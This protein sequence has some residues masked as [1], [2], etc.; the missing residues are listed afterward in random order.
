M[1]AEFIYQTCNK[2]QHL[3]PK[4]HFIVI[5]IIFFSVVLGFELRAWSLLGLLG[6]HSY[7]WATPLEFLLLFFLVRE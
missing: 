2:F 4:K 7:Y 5:I 3:F 6:R 1:N